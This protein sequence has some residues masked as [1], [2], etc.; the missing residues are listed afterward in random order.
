MKDAKSAVG[1]FLPSVSPLLLFVSLLLLV[2]EGGDVS[3]FYF[4]Q[5][6]QTQ[7][8]LCSQ[9]PT[10][11]A[12]DNRWALELCVLRDAKS[13][14][15]SAHNVNGY[16]LLWRVRPFDCDETGFVS[17]NV[18]D[19]D[20]VRRLLGPHEFFLLVEGAETFWIPQEHLGN[21]TYRFRFRLSI[22][23]QRHRLH[24]LQTRRNFW[25]FNEINSSFLPQNDVVAIADKLF[26]TLPWPSRIIPED[27][28]IEC[29]QS[30]EAGR[31][32]STVGG[33]VLDGEP[34]TLKRDLPDAQFFVDLRTTSAARWEPFDCKAPYIAPDDFRAFADGKRLDFAGDSHMRI[35]FNHLLR[36]FCGVENAASKGWGYSQCVGFGEMPLCPKISA[37]F[38]ASFFMTMDVT[39]GH[40]HDRDALIISYGNHPASVHWTLRAF[41]T[42]TSRILTL[43]ASEVDKTGRRI[44]IY[45]LGQHPIPFSTHQWAQ[46]HADGRTFTRSLMFER[47]AREIAAHFSNVQYINIFSLAMAAIQWS[48]DGA[49]LVGSDPG[50]DGVRDM[51]LLH[52]RRDAETVGMLS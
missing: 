33:S 47:S 20:N 45:F 1:S 36:T 32:V 25:G 21:C 48:Q 22:P 3:S 18:A 46:E 51:L 43:F 31:F 7:P 19:A 10:D 40:G 27:R 24:L 37:C 16:F 52:L 28:T 23:A 34:I 14:G 15:L 11:S 42:H 13:R 29:A 9:L 39:D 17:V 41:E 6:L 12:S 30:T 2:F 5:Q 38:L 4:Q 8:A 44:P 49:H 50:L 35:L 26:F